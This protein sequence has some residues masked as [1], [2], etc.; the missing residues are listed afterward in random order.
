MSSNATGQQSTQ[1]QSVQGLM[2]GERPNPATSCFTVSV[3][4]FILFSVN[5]DPR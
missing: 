2:R 4:T 5:F 3:W 1:T